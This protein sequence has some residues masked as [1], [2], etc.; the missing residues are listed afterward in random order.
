MLD[1]VSFT[2]ATLYHECWLNTKR[3]LL[4]CRN[5]PLPYGGSALFS[6]TSD[7]QSYWLA[8]MLPSPN[9]WL[10][11]MFRGLLA[12]SEQL[13]LSHE[14]SNVYILRREDVA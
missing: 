7:D 13:D 5:N 1:D 12:L 8:A 14:R 4:T 2:T 10:A 11:F 9:E 3:I 6:M